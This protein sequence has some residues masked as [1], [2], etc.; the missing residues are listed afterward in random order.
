[1][2]PI[3]YTQEYHPFCSL[4]DLPQLMPLYSGFMCN[5]PILC[6][7]GSSSRP[8][9]I[10]VRKERQPNAPVRGFDGKRRY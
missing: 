9:K 10:P 7:L 6:N 1:M 8:D 4:K 3:S 2:Y 5:T